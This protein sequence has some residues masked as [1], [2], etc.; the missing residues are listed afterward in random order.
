MRNTI[1]GL[2]LLCIMGCPKINHNEN[3]L[4]SNKQLLPLDA[5]DVRLTNAGDVYVTF[6]WRGGYFMYGY[7]QGGMIVGITKEQH[8]KSWKQK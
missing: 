2:A 5:T 8:E 6:E 3:E 1:I 4:I 7:N